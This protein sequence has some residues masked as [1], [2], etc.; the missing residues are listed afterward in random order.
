[1][2]NKILN[3]LI[4]SIII[5]IPIFFSP[6]TF[7]ALEFNKLYLLCFLTW[8]A[9]LFWFLKILVKK[10][11]KVKVGD[12][13]CG[14]EGSGISFIYKVIAVDKTHY[15]LKE[16]ETEFDIRIGTVQ[17]VLKLHIR[18]VPKNKLSEVLYPNYIESKCGQYLQDR[19]D[20]EEE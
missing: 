2:L 20:Y 6:I 1:M 9:L 19:R 5:L 4:Y 3:I 14:K 11:K 13:L 15:I 17:E 12:I 18:R 16:S 7:E 8:L 10:G